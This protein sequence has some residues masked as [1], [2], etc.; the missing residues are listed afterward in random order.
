MDSLFGKQAV[1]SLYIDAP[2]DGRWYFVDGDEVT[3]KV[4]LDLPATREIEHVR[5]ILRC[6]EK[7]KV[8]PDDSIVMDREKGTY[9]WEKIVQEHYSF[10]HQIFPKDDSQRGKQKRFKGGKHEIPFKITLPSGALPEFTD[11]AP[12]SGVEWK[13]KAVVSFKRQFPLFIPNNLTT[14]CHLPVCPRESG[15]PYSNQSSTE[16]RRKV[17]KELLE[18]LSVSV[19]VTIPPGPLP[20]PPTPLGWRLEV[21]VE[22]SDAEMVLKQMAITAVQTGTRRTS[23][24]QWKH[25]GIERLET[26]PRETPEVLVLQD[27]DLEVGPGYTDLSALLT[28]ITI[29]SGLPGDILGT[30]I[31]TDRNIIVHLKFELSDKTE[32]VIELPFSHV[33]IASPSESA[34]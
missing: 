31:T 15:R 9:G 2:I 5:L 21:E 11:M 20:Q 30:F 27:F 8:L 4:V 23:F 17:R 7:A 29:T 32:H 6:R 25:F 3:G 12:G 14:K 18:G 34:P 16:N 33:V 24:T 13:L 22:H 10:R 1:P 26:K 19:V 28:S